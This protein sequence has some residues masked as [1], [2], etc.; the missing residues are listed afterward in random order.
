MTPDDCE[1]GCRQH[2]GPVRSELRQPRHSA[3]GVFYLD[4]VRQGELLRRI[5][6]A[7]EEVVHVVVC[8]LFQLCLGDISQEI[9]RELHPYTAQSR[10]Q[11]EGALFRSL[12]RYHRHF[13]S[14][15]SKANF[16]VI[17]Y[18][19]PFNFNTI[20]QNRKQKLFYYISH[21]VRNWICTTNPGSPPWNS[22]DCINIMCFRF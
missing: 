8:W 7:V 11:W 6:V 18:K 9:H 4:G 3:W 5:W 1:Y 13:R 19:N 17:S 21:L 16:T 14:K 20:T 22:A 2:T 10:Q 15:T 12:V